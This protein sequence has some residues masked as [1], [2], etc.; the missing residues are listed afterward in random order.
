MTDFM[1]SNLEQAMINVCASCPT[2]AEAE[3]K[4]RIETAERIKG[5]YPVCSAD[6]NMHLD[7][8]IAENTEATIKT[9]EA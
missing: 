5:D 3:R 7:Q 9:R 4:A 1:P 2:I 6:L 8:I